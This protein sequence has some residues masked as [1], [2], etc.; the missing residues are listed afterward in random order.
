MFHA[1]FSG[2]LLRSESLLLAPSDGDV[3]AAKWIR[4]H[5]RVSLNVAQP[6]EQYTLF[7]LP[8]DFPC[9]SS[10]TTARIRESVCVRASAAQQRLVLTS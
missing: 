6:L 2:S 10:P 1:Y 7:A 4:A 3:A 5:Y 8:L 9:A